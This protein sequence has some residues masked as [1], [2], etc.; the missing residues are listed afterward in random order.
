MLPGHLAL[1]V[2]LKAFFPHVSAAPVIFG[3]AAHDILWGLT[4]LANVEHIQPDRQGSGP[5][6]FF[7]LTSI[8][9]THSL[10]TASLLSLAWAAAFLPRGRSS[11][12][13]ALLAA[14]SH[15]ASDWL[16][17]NHDMALYPGSKEYFGCSLFKK[18]GVY[19]W[20]LEAVFTGVL[21]E[22]ARRRMDRRGVSTKP[23]WVIAGAMAVNMSP[24]LSPLWYVA[25]LEQPLA[26]QVAGALTIASLGAPCAYLTY[27][28]NKEE[29][30]AGLRKQK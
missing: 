14:L 21:L 10:L 18:L 7:K 19:E 11:A 16:T 12:V 23:A 15:I 26:Q 24:W 29:R 30:K 13:A 4:L 1:G 9:L 2:A 17:H 25:G 22:V 8:D 27:Y 3:C 5:Y 28:F 6:L 20:A